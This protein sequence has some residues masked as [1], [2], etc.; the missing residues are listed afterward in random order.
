MLKGRRKLITVSVLIILMLSIVGT[1]A[2]T[3][4]SAAIIN[5]WVG[6]GSGSPNDGSDRP[7]GTLHNNHEENSP[8]KQVFIENWGNEEIFVRIRLDEYM[9]L[10]NGAGNKSESLDQY[11]NPIANPLN[12][13]V[14]L[15]PGTDINDTTT[16]R[17][18][19]PAFRTYWQLEMGG[20][21]YFLPVLQANQASESYVSN[22][23]NAVVTEDSLNDDGVPARQTP[24]AQVMTMAQ[25]IDSGNPIG[26][27]WV[28]DED[29]WAYWASSIQ[30]GNVTGLLV[31]G[32]TSVSQPYEDYYFGIHVDAQMATKDLDELDNFERFGAVEHGGWTADGEMLM[33]LITDAGESPG[34]PDISETYQNLYESIQIELT[35]AAAFRVFADVAQEEGFPSIANLFLAAAYA[36]DRHVEAQWEV[37]QSMGATVMPEAEILPV[38]TTA[39]NLE[40]AYHAEDDAFVIIFEG[41]LDTAISEGYEDAERV[42]RWALGAKKTH[43]EA[44]SAALNNLDNPSYLE[45][46]D[47]VYVCGPCGEVV[48]ERP[49]RCPTCD[50]P[51]EGYTVFRR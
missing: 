32:I 17:H 29:G 21:A 2:W 36:E 41:F 39:E 43:A 9:E 25:W 45:R 40:L 16:W 7:G 47:V 5:S 19:E 24:M 13:A 4:F 35:A 38:G 46:F 31:N 1:F 23:G 11:G 8:H 26:N 37:L 50:F 33:R 34:R 18:N 27:Y 42:L 51:G 28:I 15:I 12:E 22:I 30:P 14:P 49:E 3:N 44:F 6:L 20:Q 48:T 10:G